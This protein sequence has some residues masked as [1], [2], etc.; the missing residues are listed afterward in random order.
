MLLFPLA[1]LTQ[2]EK[3]QP[4]VGAY[5][6]TVVATV[7]GAA[8][9]G[10][11]VEGYLWDWYGSLAIQELVNYQ[12]VK[13]AADKGKVTVTDAEV[14]KFAEE[15]IAK[16]KQSQPENPDFEAS[17]RAQGV[18][19]SRILL[20]AKTQL[21]AEK[22]VANEFKP[23]DYVK[24]ATIIFKTKSASTEDLSAAL[25][26]ADKAYERLKKGAAWSAVLKDSTDNNQVIDSQGVVG[27]RA[28][29]VFPEPAQSELKTLP[30]RGVTK[31]VQTNNGIQIFQVVL[32]GSEAP[33]GELDEVRH[34]VAS[35]AAQELLRKLRKDA[36]ITVSWPAKPR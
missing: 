17:L 4:P 1:L 29:S 18:T 7:N 34:Q 16:Y 30:T 35:S 23:G 28:V 6:A 27:W 26:Q 3:I 33:S 12:L 21:L 15:Q 24:I 2:G 11:D 36:Q 13:Q 25:K 5:S 10:S 31:P 19:Q 32:K 8:I 22:L 9:T 14:S 20:R